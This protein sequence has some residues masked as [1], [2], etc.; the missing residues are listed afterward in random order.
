MITARM[1][2]SDWGLLLLLSLIWGGSFFLIALIVGHM[3]VLWVVA[4]R[5]MIAAAVLWAI[6]LATGRALPRGAG[7]WGAFLV[8]GVLNNAIPFGLIVWAQGFIPAG[9]ASI[10][11][12]TT[13]LF[14]VLVS[15]LVLADE[16]A[17]LMRLAGVA[18]GLGG[19]AVMI[20]VDELAGHGHG[21]LPQLAML[22]A[23][24]SYAWAAAF[25]RR[26]RAQGVDPLVTAAGMVTG[27]SVVLLPLALAH[28]GLPLAAP[29]QVWLAI[30][31][32]GLVC[33]GLAY[34]LFFRILGR[35]GATNISLVTF[36]VPV[37][38]ILLGW[39]FLDEVLGLPQLLGMAVI[40]L[41]LAMIDGRLLR[42]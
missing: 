2:A 33:T 18:L 21:V 34:V 10:L 25:G 4:L 27:T 28:D 35:A 1:S 39:L 26:F 23:A 16:R 29:A 8:M 22:G 41:G 12:A 42:R 31:L 32:L 19:V 36:L 7:L 5:V 30:S 24:I 38:A 40:G 17:G 37:S 20:G 6:V 14:T 9:L 13:P 11:N 15:T 3:P